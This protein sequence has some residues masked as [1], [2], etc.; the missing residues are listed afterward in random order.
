MSS[1]ETGRES[2]SDAESG[3][4]KTEQQTHPTQK[5]PCTTGRWGVVR[6]ERKS[7]A[8]A[9]AVTC[10]CAVNKTISDDIRS[11]ARTHAHLRMRTHCAVQDRRTLLQSRHEGDGLRCKGTTFGEGRTQTHAHARTRARQSSHA[12]R[13]QGGE[14]S[15]PER[16]AETGP[17][18]KAAWCSPS[19]FA[20][21]RASTPSL[22][23]THAHARTKICPGACALACTHSLTQLE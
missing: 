5:N 18:R 20:H 8:A 4:R 3:L 19:K 2:L 1:R 22:P 17:P 15:A 7:A 12:R 16:Q 13:P 21:A 11:L 14:G 9:A 10:A 6:V 23:L